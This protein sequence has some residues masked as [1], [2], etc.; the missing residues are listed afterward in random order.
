[1]QKSVPKLASSTDQ[2]W[3]AGNYNSSILDNFSDKVTI[4]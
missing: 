4:L 1:M 3:L 2:W